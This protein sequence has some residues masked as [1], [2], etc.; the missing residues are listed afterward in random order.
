VLLELL[1]LGAFFECAFHRGLI[2]IF[3]LLSGQLCHTE[4]RN[5]YRYAGFRFAVFLLF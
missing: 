2:G 4:S 3:L 1:R 5:P